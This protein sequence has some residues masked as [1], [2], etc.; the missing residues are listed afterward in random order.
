MTVSARPLPL[1]RATNPAMNPERRDLLLGDFST[2]TA[3]NARCVGCYTN[4]GLMSGVERDK[5]ARSFLDERMW[6]RL[7]DELTPHIRTLVLSGLGDATFQN[8]PMNQRIIDA[9][10]D[11]GIYV[12]L[13]TNGL[14]MDDT[15]ADWIAAR[16]GITIIGKWLH[17]D[18]A[19][20]QHLLG[21]P[22]ASRVAFRELDGVR[23]PAHIPLLMDRGLHRD[24]RLAIAS[25]LM[26]RNKAAAPDQW[27]WLRDRNIIPIFSWLVPTPGMGYTAKYDLN[28]DLSSSEK[29]ELTRACWHIDHELG[30]EW[31][32]CMGP[33]IS[34]SGCKDDR[35][36]YFGPIGDVRVCP[37]SHDTP[38]AFWPEHSVL[39]IM[40]IKA[41]QEATLRGIRDSITGKATCICSTLCTAK[42]AE[43]GGLVQLR[44]GSA[45]ASSD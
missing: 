36:L 34:A 29:E 16:P 41:Q 27:R 7:L 20:H 21:L 2:T 18:P 3:C 43:S 33:K 39:E 6:M 37:S 30:I 11:R 45:A 8:W 26:Q 31:D 23:V 22:P 38:Q 25:I 19:E 32:F 44:L 35:I 17:S 14:T 10:L 40:G 5:Y 15:M 4:A 13:F 24:N 42:P 1:L 28:E 9:S 12:L